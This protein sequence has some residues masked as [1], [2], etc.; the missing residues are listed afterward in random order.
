M[1]PPIS[2]QNQ[3]LEKK[4]LQIAKKHGRQIECIGEK[5]RNRAD[6]ADLAQSLQA[7]GKIIQ[8]HAKVAE[9]EVDIALQSEGETSSQHKECAT[10]KYSKAVDEHVKA[11]KLYLDKSKEFTKST[12]RKMQV[13]QDDL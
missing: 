12:K 11:T 8:L 4:H 10:E 13:D 2:R 7:S 6:L 1:E 9:E 5:L 3:L